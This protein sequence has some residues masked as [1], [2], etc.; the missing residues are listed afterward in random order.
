MKI[1]KLSENVSVKQDRENY[2]LFDNLNG[3]IYKLNAVSYKILSLCDGENT[4][5]DIIQNITNTFNAAKEETVKD[6]NDLMQN[7]LE[8]RYVSNI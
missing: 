8:R 5:E 7:L 3:N 6:F 2:M 1:F 4:D